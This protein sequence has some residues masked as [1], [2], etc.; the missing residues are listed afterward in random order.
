[1]EHTGATVDGTG[2]GSGIEH[3][4][5]EELDSGFGVEVESKEVR[6][7]GVWEQGCMYGGIARVLQEGFD[8]PRANE[9]IGSGDAHNFGDGVW[10]SHCLNFVGLG[11][12][13]F[14]ELSLK[15]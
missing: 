6:G 11:R 12:R 14:D 2:N 3:I 10:G 15:S 7:V 4:D 8:Q 9:A 5:L 1:M 13:K